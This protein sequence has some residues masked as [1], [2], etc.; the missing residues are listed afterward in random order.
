NIKG[1]AVDFCRPASHVAK[2]LAGSTDF[3]RLRDAKRLTIIR[4]FQFGEQRAVRFHRVGKP[5]QEALPVS[6]PQFGP[7]TLQRLARCGARDRRWW[8]DEGPWARLRS[9]L[10]GDLDQTWRPEIERLGEASLQGFRRSSPIAFHSERFCQLDEIRVGQ[11]RADKAT[12][13]GL[14]LIA[15]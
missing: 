4:G 2:V 6:R 12:L 1:L 10:D 3:E 14:L 5:E 9:F 13:V 7:R 15:L 8:M 11:I